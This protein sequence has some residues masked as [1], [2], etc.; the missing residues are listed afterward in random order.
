MRKIENIDEVVGGVVVG[1]LRLS[2]GAQQTAVMR[3]ET[4]MISSAVG[5]VDQA[6]NNNGALT[7]TATLWRGSDKVS[8]LIQSFAAAK[9]TI[10]AT[11]LPWKAGEVIFHAGR[12]FEVDKMVQDIFAE[13]DAPITAITGDD[14]VYESEVNNALLALG[15]AGDRSLFPPNGEAFRSAIVRAFPCHTLAATDTLATLVGGAL[16][17][18]MADEARADAEKAFLSAQSDVVFR[19]KDW[20][21]RI[22]SVCDPSKAR[23][24]VTANLLPD[25]ARIVEQVPKLLIVPDPDIEMAAMAIGSTFAQFDEGNLSKHASVR[26][27]AYD[28]AKQALS[29]LET[30]G[31]LV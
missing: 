23:T 18:R 4:Q 3:T 15:A 11:T 29:M 24:R 9:K 21:E 16:G 7:V 17:R 6:G 19:L 2:I 30:C 25:L 28:K 14:A 27:D 20:L 22:K 8:A 12:A 5:A 26:A 13:M 1:H 31:A 10:K